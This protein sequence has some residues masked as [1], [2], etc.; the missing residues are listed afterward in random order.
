MAKNGQYIDVLSGANDTSSAGDH[1]KSKSH[2]KIVINSVLDIEANESDGGASNDR[3]DHSQ[4]MLR[5]SVRSGAGTHSNPYNLPRSAIAQDMTH[6]SV[7][8]QILQSIV[9][10]NLLILQMLSRNPQNPQ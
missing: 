3:E 4:P 5:R 7:D 10:S 1:V 2:H 6:S 8:S 9:Q